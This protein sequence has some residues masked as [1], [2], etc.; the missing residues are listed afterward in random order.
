MHQ[1]PASFRCGEDETLERLNKGMKFC[2]MG[3]E[4]SGEEILKKSG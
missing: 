4:C 2:I 3:Y 1:L